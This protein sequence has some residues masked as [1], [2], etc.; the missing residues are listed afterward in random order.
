MK[1]YRNEQL[2][3][4]V[5]IPEQWSF[6]QRHQSSP[7]P[8]K[9]HMLVFHC[10]SCEAFNIQVK[11]LTR[12][13]DLDQTEEEFR[14]FVQERGYTSLG[15][16]R[17]TVEGEEQVWARYYTGYGNWA[18]KY[19]LVCN[20][21]E[22][23]FTAACLEQ[24]LLLEMERDWDEVAASIRLLT[25][26]TMANQPKDELKEQ[27]S[28]PTARHE[29]GDGNMESPARPNKTPAGMKTYLNEKHG[30]EID[31]PESWAP[32]PELPP[33]LM[34]ALAGPIP[35][36]INKD[37]FQYGC[38]DEAI[39]F[40][41]GPLYPEPLLDDTVIEFKVYAQVQGFKNLHF[42][43][44]NVAGKEHV[45]AHYYINDNMGPRWN[46]K[47]MLVF[48]GIEY[49]LTMTCNDPQRFARREKDWDTIIRS[50]HVLGPVDES[51]NATP[52][53][54]RDRQQRREIV[55][56]R[57]EMLQ[58]PG[59][60]YAKA[61]EA[62]ALGQYLDA[63][64]LLEEYLRLKPEHIQAH[65][66]LAAVLQKMG[67]RVGA[68]HH[69]KEVER[70]SP[71]DSANRSNLDKLVAESGGDGTPSR[72]AVSVTGSERNSSHGN[73]RSAEDESNQCYTL[74]VS[75]RSYIFIAALCF[76]YIYSRGLE[77]REL[78]FLTSAAYQPLSSSEFNMV[79]LTLFLGIGALVCLMALVGAE[80][81]GGN[82][83]VFSLIER[84]MRTYNKEQKTFGELLFS[85][86]TRKPSG[87][88]DALRLQIANLFHA[89]FK[90]LLIYF[91]V[92]ILHPV[93]SLALAALVFGPQFILHHSATI[94]WQAGTALV[95]FFLCYRA[96]LLRLA[97]MKGVT[98]GDAA[99]SRQVAAVPSLESSTQAAMTKGVTPEFITKILGQE[100]ILLAIK[101]DLS[102]TRQIGYKEM[103]R[104]GLITPDQDIFDPNRPQ[105]SRQEAMK[106]VLQDHNYRL[107]LAEQIPL[108]RTAILNNVAAFNIQIDGL[109]VT[110][111][112]KDASLH[113]RPGEI[114]K[115]NTK[116]N[117]NEFINIR[118]IRMEDSLV[119]NEGRSRPLHRFLQEEGFPLKETYVDGDPLTTLRSGTIVLDKGKVEII[120]PRYFVQRS[121]ID[122]EGNLIDLGLDKNF[123]PAT[124]F[125]VKM[126]P[127]VSEALIRHVNSNG[128]VPVLRYRSCPFESE[129]MLPI[130]DTPMSA[131]GWVDLFINP[132]GKARLFIAR[133]KTQAEW[134]EMMDR[135]R[136]LFYAEL[137]KEHCHL[138]ALTKYKIH[139]TYYLF[140]K[141]KILED[142][143]IVQDWQLP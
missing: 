143:F 64:A 83:T 53:A 7:V 44:I 60:A 38:Y 41:I 12:G 75:I 81:S 61:Y 56:E 37:C 130:L 62:M 10:R 93:M 15:L 6:E 16:G 127:S 45:C 129:Y 117:E 24:N 30:F 28:V 67:D 88:V 115:L 63:R 11:S 114:Y 36:G 86:Y 109:V 71:S 73:V 107:N 116:L 103:W 39:N 119:F 35:P 8:G 46:K 78:L 118:N 40:E 20:Q 25:S 80:P 23:T 121:L 13:P 134:V 57:I 141:Q 139:L 42:G 126:R 123:G 108:G 82:S 111:G 104:L 14:R 132:S 51:A 77:L 72:K 102:K 50:F 137:A 4:E 90:I 19:V 133:E 49:A 122:D 99:H 29:T 9:G 3:F 101:N 97:K 85:D 52:K 1:T 92:G 43:R 128:Y 21:V 66:D 58:D 100:N 84:T 94:L 22:F 95:W 74:N 68:A 96:M 65:K 142:Y 54:D 87:F 26:G 79:W 17:F 48:G 138:L 59:K 33:G 125:D 112:T 55:Q 136:Q 31:L 140:Q 76:V 120:Y 34:D 89:F 110:S 106:K 47:Y 113:G 32:A 5:S 105:L 27:K 135:L 124:M 131:N 2:G 91:S 18:K 70:L 98:R 69:L